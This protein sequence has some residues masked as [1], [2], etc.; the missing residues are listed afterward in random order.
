MQALLRVV[1]VYDGPG[2]GQ[3][4]VEVRELLDM[5]PGRSEFHSIEWHHEGDAGRG[6]K[7][8]MDALLS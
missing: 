4:P 1:V 6:R 3:E 7:H 5:A 8:F 2:D